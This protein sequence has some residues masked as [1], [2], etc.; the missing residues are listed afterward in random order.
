MIK[1]DRVSPGRVV[2][3]ANAPITRNATSAMQ[4]WMNRM[5][6]ENAGVSSKNARGGRQVRRFILI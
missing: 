3:R 1:E 2:G 5:S 4:H 6:C